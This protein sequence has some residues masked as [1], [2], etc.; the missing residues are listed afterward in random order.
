MED[1]DGKIFEL[2]L[3]SCGL[4]EE[5]WDKEKW[6]NILSNVEMSGSIT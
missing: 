4:N 6:Q 3:N 2:V 5:A 1:K